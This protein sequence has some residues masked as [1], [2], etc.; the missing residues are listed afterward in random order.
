[1]RDFLL[2]VGYDSE[3]LE[4]LRT[5]KHVLPVGGARIGF[6]QRSNS[7]D[8]PSYYTPELADTVRRRDRLIFTLFPEFDRAETAS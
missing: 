3:D 6:A 5:L 7:E 1:L 8:W 2:G 4:F